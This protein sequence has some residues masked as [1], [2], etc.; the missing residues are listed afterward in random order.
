MSAAWTEPSGAPF[1]RLVHLHQER[2]FRFA[3]RLTGNRE[4]AED[5]VQ[6]GLLEAYVA[7]DRFQPG[8]HFD[9]WLFRILRHT[10]LDSV[11]SRPRVTIES[12]EQPCESPEGLPMGAREIADTR[13]G[14]EEEML[15]GTL[16]EPLERALDA[17][18]S[19][20]RSVVMLVELQE[21]S[22]E[23]AARALGRPVGTVRS[24]LHR[25]RNLL[26]RTLG[27]AEGAQSA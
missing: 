27:S 10:Y 25:A 3:R 26:R 13:A 21:M 7:F 1:E 12:L 8:T 17:L 9:R 11:R 5:L 6:Q 22:Y 23:E 15:A 24:R 14:P 19:E 4:D 2:L 18:P 20:Y 16:S